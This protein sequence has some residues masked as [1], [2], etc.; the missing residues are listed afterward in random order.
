MSSL[1][2]STFTGD[3]TPS[4]PEELERGDI[5]VIGHEFGAPK[6][7]ADIIQNPDFN[8]KLH[9]NP[10]LEDDPGPGDVNLVIAGIIA[11]RFA[12]KP[13]YAPNSVARALEEEHDIQVTGLLLHTSSN[14]DA[15]E[16]GT[17]EELDQV[18]ELVGS[19]DIIRSIHV[20][21]AHHINRIARQARL[22]GF[23]PMLP[24]G[25]P[26]QFDPESSQWWCRSVWAWGLRE[27]PGLAVLRHRDQL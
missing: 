1:I 4:T 24:E 19:E 23:D 15:S 13:I 7:P 25:L 6:T 27:I 26:K 5:V 10:E 20:G 14:A 16:G 12:D 3:Y 18:K 21:Q 8:P 9:Y 2:I 17:W 11:S 22:K